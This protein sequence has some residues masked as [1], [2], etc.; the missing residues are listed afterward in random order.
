MTGSATSTAVLDSWPG[1]RLALLFIAT[2]VVVVLR[3]HEVL[4]L[5]VA[6]QATWPP[7]PVGTWAHPDDAAF[8]VDS[9]R[10]LLIALAASLPML[11]LI[12][13]LAPRAGLRRSTV[14]TAVMT[15]LVVMALLATPVPQLVRAVI[16]MAG[17]DGRPDNPATY[18]VAP[19]VEELLKLLAIALALAVARQRV[20]LRGGLLAGAAVGLG[21]TILE[22]VGYSLASLVR[23]SDADVLFTIA[24]RFYW[25]GAGLHTATA[26]L[27]GAGLSAFLAHASRPGGRASARVG[28]VILLGALVA[29]MLTHGTWNRLAEDLVNALIV[30]LGPTAALPPVAFVAA[31]LAAVPFLLGPWVALAIAWRRSA[32]TPEA[33][34]PSAGTVQP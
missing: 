34:E 4:A 6:D 33:T 9:L 2:V 10:V 28:A 15:G 26:A 11:L 21:V 18:L 25:L 19:V 12:A 1:R 32:G 31:S 8:A 17:P 23:Q 27:T 13:R 22:A 20:G 29:A 24:L 3:S 7:P 5:F 14:L 16:G 30:P